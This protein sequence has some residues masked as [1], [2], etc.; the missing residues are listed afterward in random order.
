MKKYLK[1]KPLKKFGKRVLS[2]KR[3]SVIKPK[4]KLKI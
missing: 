2:T 1:L 4:G 3:C